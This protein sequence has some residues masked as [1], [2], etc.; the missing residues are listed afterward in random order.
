MPTR[1]PMPLSQM[2]SNQLPHEK[3]IPHTKL[4]RFTF[5]RRGCACRSIEYGRK[6]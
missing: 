2:L 5:F 6:N 1:I 4:I 3:L